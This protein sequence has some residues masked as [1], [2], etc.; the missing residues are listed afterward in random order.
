MQ[1]YEEEYQKEK[2]IYEDKMTEWRN[3]LT[4]E[5]IR[6]QQAYI[7]DQ[8]KKGKKVTKPRLRV[9]DQPKQPVTSFFHFLAEER[10]K[11]GD[12]SVKDMAKQAGAKWKSMSAEEKQVSSRITKKRIAAGSSSSSFPQP[13]VD[14]SEAERA[15]YATAMQ[16]FKASQS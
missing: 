15:A 12:L 9:T 1:P 2:A 6:R 8:Q 16:D 4:A 7:R 14:K 5:D 11:Q 3:S 10:A 13:Y